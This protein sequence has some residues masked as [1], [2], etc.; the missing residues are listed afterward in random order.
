MKRVL[1]ALILLAAIAATA[2]AVPPALS[3]PSLSPDGREVAFVSGGDIWTAP[4]TGGEAHLLISN[5]ATESRPF[6]SP[7][8]KRLA[9]I[10]DRTG[11]G[12]IY[13]VDL[14]G[15]ALTRVTY[16]SSLDQLDGWSRDGQ[17]L[18]FTSSA[19]EIA[20]MN[21]VY[22][23]RAS[24]GTPM[25]VTHER[26][27][28]EFFSAPAPD[29][30]RLA[31]AARGN[32]SGQWW[33]HGHSH[34]DESEIWLLDDTTH[35]YQR[36]TEGGA[37]HLWPMWSAD[38]RRVFYVSDEGGAENVWSLDMATSKP[39]KLTSFTK[40]RVLWP[41][42]S[43]SGD[44]IVFERDYGVWKLDT[45]TNA[46]APL[47]LTLRGVAA[48]PAVEH[49]TLTSGIDEIAV[50][51][52]GK[53]L[54]FLVRGEVFAAPSSDGTNARRVTST[55]AE[56][57]HVTWS[58]DG[59]KLVYS[60][61]RNGM[62]A[63]YQYDFGTGAETRLTTSGKD[64]FVPHF[65]P[66][67]KMLAYVRGGGELHVLTLATNDDRLVA[68]AGID[69]APPLSDRE[70]I[71]WSPDSKW[72]AYLANGERFFRNAWVVPAA[73]GTPRAVSFL[74]NT[75]ADTISW[76]G[77]GRSLYFA[78]GQ[79]SE[80]GE[81]ARVDLL[82]RVPKFREEQFRELFKDE[83][84]KED[85]KT[86]DKAKPDALAP[87]KTADK[88]SSKIDTDI[89]FEGINRR[90]TFLP[91]GLSVNG[92]RVSPDGKNLALIAT[93]AGQ[94]NVYVYSLDEL[95][96]EP[97]VA[98]QLT[99]TSG[100]KSSLQ[101]TADSKELWLL[102]DG[103][104]LRVTVED[105]KT[106]NVAVA[107]E[108]DVDFEAEKMVMF[109][110]AWTWERDNFHDP[111]MNGADWEALHEEIGSRVAAARTYDEVR[112]LLSLMIG[113]LNASHLGVRGTGGRSSSGRI[114]LR[115]ER[116]PFENSGKFIVS[117]V[118]PLSPADIT[119]KIKVGDVITAVDGVELTGSTNFERL[120][121]FRTG[122]EVRL[123]VAGKGIVEVQP[124][125]PAAEKQL[126]YRAWVQ[127]NRDYV[128]RISNGRIGYVHM[129][130]MSSD[131]LA[132]LSIDLDAEN[133]SRDGVVIDIRN[134]NGGFVNAYAL[135]VFA[136]RPYLN[137][138]FRGR[139][140]ATARTLLGQRALQRPTVLVTNQ[141]SLSDAEDFSEGYHALGLGKIVGEPT[142]GWIIY[143]SNVELIDGTIFRLPFITVTT[144]KG[145]PMEMHPRPVDI[146]VTRAIGEDAGGKDSQ[147]DAAVE[148][149]Q[150]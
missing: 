61:A 33:R 71:C 124:I 91:I 70:T 77:D 149:L 43:Y 89:V 51:N 82:P 136:R 114:G 129:F 54:A 88:K 2:Q 38:G 24:G 145:E 132:Q 59:R 115:F 95:A 58:P 52:D 17:W 110:Q 57:R 102:D 146:A 46:A 87:D 6:Y 11:N 41:S 25:P 83:P 107:G 49:R 9:F 23:V 16:D 97:A 66:D 10:S 53:K 18:Y 12:D 120:L 28:N 147:L 122:K 20:G 93:A 98:K 103:R 112:R 126:T 139:P 133:Q 135:D 111:K 35:G 127:H 8:G 39:T 29:G 76:S 121:E 138:T 143:T 62:L 142:S 55:P 101:W 73:G 140:T 68:T 5:A 100:S 109:R 75:G 34:L 78:T 44:A 119:R 4:A 3:E 47:A 32:A 99:S 90:T 81:A 22:R 48:G 80:P 117:E 45:K 67:G 134:N 123:T 56:E 106:K 1:L 15:G 65:S 72:I 30:K 64:D 130:D 118:I 13:L 31:F 96:K 94:D 113:E 131:S 105:G 40:G 108:M 84:K 63:L 42:I 85:D 116:E 79:R 69:F 125:A 150:R 27:T 148:A 144:D 50:S 14:A 141:H 7:D 104:P 26:Y 137:M 92:V 128:S 60:S 86:A 19:Q 21:D 37:K 74:G 36:L